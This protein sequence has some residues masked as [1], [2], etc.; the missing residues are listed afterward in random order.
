LIETKAAELSSFDIRSNFWKRNKHT[1][2]DYIL[3]DR[4]GHISVLK[5][6]TR[7]EA[8]ISIITHGLKTKGN[9]KQEDMERK[10]VG[11]DNFRV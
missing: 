8:V 7:I 9:Q 3:M 2:V 5:Q 11:T 1:H 6:L 4:L 10:N